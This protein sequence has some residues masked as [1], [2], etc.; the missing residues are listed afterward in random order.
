MEVTIKD[1]HIF[2]GNGI[3]LGAPGALKPSVRAMSSSDMIAE[4]H[5]SLISKAQPH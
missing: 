4:T 3:I 2:R 1:I 5:R